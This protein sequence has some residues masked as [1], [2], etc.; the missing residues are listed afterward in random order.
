MSKEIFD[1]RTE[2]QQNSQKDLNYSHF[3]R[4]AQ[5]VPGVLGRIFRRL[6]GNLGRT[7]FKIVRFARNWQILSD[8]SKRKTQNE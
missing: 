6:R 5:I 2:F 3:T 7:K 1:S 4:A 8:R